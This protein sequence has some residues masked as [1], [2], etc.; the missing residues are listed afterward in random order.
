MAIVND[1]RMKGWGDNV[2]GQLGLGDMDRRGDD[3]NEMAS[4]LP[5]IS[6]GT[7]RT[8][9]EVRLGVDSSC[10]LL[11]NNTLK[12]WGQNVAGE[13]GAEDNTSVGGNPGEMGDY[14][15]PVSFPTAS[16]I[17][18][19]AAGWYQYGMISTVGDLYTWGY[20]EYG[21]LGKEFTNTWGNGPNEM[22][23]YLINTDVGTG[24]TVSEFMGGFFHSCVLMDNFRM[25]CFGNCDY[26]KF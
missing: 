11:D 15:N 10:V 18:K 7:G 4:Y 21:Q 14:L 3:A 9:S 8:A 25:K 23:N 13:I 20:N 5:W 26:G 6:L 2:Y 19:I 24:R 22:G 12:C 16:T 17:S 1:G